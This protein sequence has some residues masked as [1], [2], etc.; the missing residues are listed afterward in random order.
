LLMDVLLSFFL[1]NGSWTGSRLAI[2]GNIN[3]AN[4]GYY[5]IW[6]NAVNDGI[7]ALNADLLYRNGTAGAVGVPYII[8]VSVD[9]TGNLTVSLINNGVTL[10][11]RAG[12]GFTGPFYLV[13]GQGEGAP[14]T[15]QSQNVSVWQYVNVTP[16][17]FLSLNNVVASQAQGTNLV[18]ISYD[19]SGAS[20]P[21]FVSALVSTNGGT[22]YNIQ[23][24]S[25]S[26]DGATVPVGSGPGHQLVWNA[27]IDLPNF[28]SSN[29]RIKL[30]VPSGGS[31]AQAVSPI[32]TLDTRTAAI[33]GLTGTIL[34]TNGSPIANAQ[35]GIEQ[36]VLVTSTL[37]NGTF[38][39][40]NIPADNGYVLDVSAAGYAPKRLTSVNVPVGG[41]N[42]VPIILTN[43]SGPISLIP[44]VPDVNAAITTVEQGGTAYRYYWVGIIN[45]TNQTPL[46]GIPV[47]VQI[48]GGGAIPQTNDIS[49]F[50]PGETAGV[51]FWDGSG[52]VCI[53]IPASALNTNGTV[54][55]IQLNIG[56]QVQ[57]SFQAQVV[58]SQYDQVWRQSIGGGVGVTA[59]IQLGVQESS[60]SDIRHTL[61]NGSVADESISR[62]RSDKVQ[63]GVGFN[64]GSSLSLAS[65]NISG[66]IGLGVSSELR[67]TYAF[68]PN[69]TDS[70][71]NAM[72]LYVDLGNIISDPSIDP[73]G[74]AFYNLVDQ[75]IAPSFLG[76]NSNSVEGDLL[77]GPYVQGSANFSLGTNIAH[78]I[79]AQVGIQAG[80]SADAEGVSGFE[81]TSGSDST[82]AV[83]KGIAA[84]VSMGSSVYGEL[85]LISGNISNGISSQYTFLSSGFSAEAITKTW[86]L[87][88]QNNPYLTESV[89]QLSLS[90]GQQNTIMP[91]WQQYDP[92]AL[93]SNFNREY[94]ETWDTLTG[95]SITTYNRSL[96]AYEVE[97]QGNLGVS[98]GLGAG[99]NLNFQGELDR[100]AEVVN[101]RG[102]IF[103]PR[104]WSASPYWPTE[105]YPAMT[106]NLFPTE[107]WSSLLSGWA[108]DATDPID[109]AIHS[110]IT[111]FQAG[112]KTAI[113]SGQAD[114]NLAANDFSNAFSG[115]V[116]VTSSY[117]TN[118]F[119]GLSHLALVE[120]QPLGGPIGNGVAYLPAD[121]TSNYNYGIGGVYRFAS[122]NV[123]SGTATL[124]ISYTNTD[125]TG[126]D[127]TQFQIYQLPDGTNRWQLMGGSVD[128]NT[129]TV[130]VTITNLG[131]F[132]IAPPL[133]TG[134]LQ[135]ILSANALPADGTSQMTMTITNLML[136]TGNVATQQWLFTAS[137]DGVQILNPDCDTN[138]PGIQVVS[139]N[140]VITLLLQAPSGGT[141]AH[142]SLASVAGDACG[143]AEINIIDTTPPATPTS[144]VVTGYQSRISLSWTANT[145][146]DLVGYRVY[147]NAGSA[148]PP[149]NGT[150]AIEGS[151]SPVS[152]TGTNCLLRGLSLGT[153]YFIAVSA[154][155]T[156]GNESPKS[157]TQ[158]VTTM[159]VPPMPP[160]GVAVSFGSDGTNVLMWALSE[161]DGYNDRDVTQ[162][163]IWRAILPGGSYTNIGQVA[164][165]ISVFTD[166][167][168]TVASGQTVS[169]AVSAVTAFGS[170]STQVVA[171]V[172]APASVA[173]TNVVIG[174]SQ[175]LANGQFQLTVNGGV[176]GQNFV[177][178]ASTNLVDWTPIR[179]FVDTNPPI[180][181]YD[182]DAAKYRWR[183]YRI[184]PASTAPAMQFGLNSAQ[185]I[186]SNGF[187]V[188]LYSLPGLNY[189]IE[190]S[191]NLADWTT[192]TNF[193]S[194]NSPFYLSIP[195]ATDAK[196]EF[197]RAVIP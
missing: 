168:P 67:S 58:P 68:D 38:T 51:S 102:V 6:K 94:T 178:L 62:L 76:S 196:Q 87:E 64:V 26:G 164:A 184:G 156:T 54:Q 134:D 159:P 7:C 65:A 181:I 43:V 63:V 79:N 131:T 80:I 173:S 149:W 53:A 20:A 25:L 129:E 70:E 31:F 88:G 48:Q 13:L 137:A 130:T 30:S 86:T 163:Y 127:P 111:N 107:S 172:V 126:L 160:T 112:V 99:L 197:Y 33:G 116:Q 195:T 132:A 120:Y 166:P 19:L 59:L 157:P 161:D 21:V 44:L 46:G 121:G 71:Q 122:T 186:N 110:A 1:S 75:T 96:Y 135:L 124:T 9:A 176:V 60:E 3:S 66:G 73:I 74:N 78:V 32:F 105:S 82:S 39:L 187:N 18:N 29:M 177:L 169:Y 119:S 136:N 27:G 42:L 16:T 191:T 104:H 2:F 128:T 144:V 182:P 171:T 145:E 37:S 153:N 57:T 117:S 77:A 28:F 10:A 113:Q 179:G 158:E 142:V 95:S 49:N 24:V 50:W 125:I 192:I 72:K 100:G 174:P 34:T 108:S 45:G 103:Q 175:L 167:N 109:Q 140:G 190:A 143:S 93:S 83:I 35:V 106:T 92:S 85:D 101:E 14:C 139:T 81:A 151:P 22:N 40:S 170:S 193:V 180:T 194:T 118:L 147:Y 47:A 165:G 97:A 23:P 115:I 133:P 4:C 154:V 162:Y 56:G 188:V 98:L 15:G 189:E 91:G 114:L 148:G 155:D 17:T 11:Q 8:Q 183:F 41:T 5:G 61:I 138:L 90:A 89:Q 141:V 152:V 36:P 55:T 84:D 185:P 12:S 123:F 69:T 52:I 150:A 146:P